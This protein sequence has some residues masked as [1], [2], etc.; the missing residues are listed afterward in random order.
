VK[1]PCDISITADSEIQSTYYVYRKQ[2]C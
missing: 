2:E 1:S